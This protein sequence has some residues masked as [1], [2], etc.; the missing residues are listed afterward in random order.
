VRRRGGLRPQ[1]DVEPAE[2]RATRDGLRRRRP[3]TRQRAARRTHGPQTHSPDHLAASGKPLA[4]KANRDGGA[5]RCPEPAGPQRVAVDRALIDAEARRRRA[6]EVTRVQTA[7]AH[8]A[9]ARDRRHSGPGIGPMLRLVRRDATHASRRFPRG[10]ACVADG[11]RRTGATAAAG[12]RDG[13]AGATLGTTPLTWAFAQAAVLWLRHHPAAR[14]ELARLE[15]HHGT[16]QALPSM[17]PQSARA[18]SDLRTR[19][20]V[21]AMPKG[22]HGSG[23]GAEEPTAELDAHGLS[24]TGGARMLSVRQGTR[25]SPEGLSPCSRGR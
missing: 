23:R 25:R 16:G 9:Q 6:G 15:P 3:R 10:Q 24:L 20:P 22:R 18:V 7:Q 2:R 1:A 12:T 21:F 5:G 11:R 13:P 14:Q 17:A 19:E 4:S 8:Q